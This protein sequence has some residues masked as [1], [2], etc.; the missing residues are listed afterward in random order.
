MVVPWAATQLDCEDFR[1][2]SPVRRL[3]PAPF[4]N[5]P[6]LCLP[7]S[8]AKRCRRSHGRVERL[9]M[10]GPLVSRYLTLSKGII[11]S[12][13]LRGSRVCGRFPKSR[14]E[15]LMKCTDLLVQDHKI[16]LRAL[17]VIEH[18]AARVENDQ[19]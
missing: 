1:V 19:F 8:V 13:I 17:N 6:W 11:R 5:I 2:A 10:D 4:P 9:A 7:Q 12:C 15:R 18:M 14:K 3:S 16:I